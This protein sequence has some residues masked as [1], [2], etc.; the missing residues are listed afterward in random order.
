MAWTHTGERS[1]G[2]TGPHARHRAD[3]QGG[4]ENGQRRGPGAGGGVRCGGEDALITARRD[5]VRERIDRLC[6]AVAV[7][8]HMLQC[9]ADHPLDCPVTGA[10]IRS[11]VDAA[12]VGEE[13]P[14]PTFP[15]VPEES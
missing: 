12:L 1:F 4:D 6:R 10:Y 14:E 7:L 15:D 8:R 5:A 13:H 11:R 3:E 9:P 2:V